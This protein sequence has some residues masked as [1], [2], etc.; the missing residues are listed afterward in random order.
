[1]LS[2]SLP[3]LLFEEYNRENQGRHRSATLQGHLRQFLV[4]RIRRLHKS[5]RKR[6][7]QRERREFSSSLNHAA[8]RR[9]RFGDF[10]KQP[11][12]RSANLD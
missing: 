10:A 1:M 2:P 9:R 7:S 4:G 6:P 8:L 11:L 3:A 12:Q 5:Q